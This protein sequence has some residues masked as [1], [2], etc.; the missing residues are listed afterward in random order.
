MGNIKIGL[1]I[2]CQLLAIN[3]ILGQLT[4]RGHVYEIT[5][6][7]DS[8]PLVGATLQL[9]DGSAG[10][11][12]DQE[13]AF[14]M[15]IPKSGSKLIV[16]YVGYTSDTII[17]SGA[18]PLKVYLREGYTMNAVEVSHRQKSTSISYLNPLKVEQISERE[19]LKAA[20]CNLSESFETNPSIDVSFTDAITG[21]RQIQLL[22]LAGPYTQF[23]RESIPDIRGFS[24]IYGLGLIPGTWIQSIQLS[25]GMGTV[26]NGFE[27][28]AGQINVELKK[29]ESGEKWLF[30]LYGNEL[31][32]TEGNLHW[33]HE[34]N[35]KWSTGILS[36]GKFH[37]FR[38][39]RN[40]D[41]FLD[42]PLGYT[43]TVL[44]RWKYAGADG[45]EAQFG[46]KGSWQD[47]FSGQT[48]FRPR[49][50][51]GST[52][53]WGMENRLN[54]YEGW[55]KIGKVFLSRPGTSI[56]LQV[57]GSIQQQD[58]F[59]GLQQY[60][61]DQFSAY[62][63]L[64]FESLIG[65][66]AH[67]YR[68]GAS[69]Q[70]DN[71]IEQLGDTP[72]DRIEWV[73]GVWG[74]YTYKY[75]DKVTLVLGLRADYHNQFGAFITPRMHFRYAPFEKTAFRVSAGR[76]QRTANIF[77]EN[78]GLLASARQL[79]V[80][81]ERENTPYGLDAEVAWNFGFNFTQDFRLDYRNGTFTVDLYRT[82]FQNQIVVDLDQSPQQALFYNLDGRSFAN[83]IQVQ[84]DYELIKR[85]DVRIAYRWYDLK[86]TY[87]G[88][89][90]QK[91][92][93]AA[94]RS[95]L[96]L[97]Y[98]TRTYWAFDGTL[99]WHG[100]KR[101]PRTASNPTA[102]QLEER[103]PDFITVNM[104]I[105]KTWKERLDVYVG[106]E[107]L[108]NF[109]QLNPILAADDPFGPFFDASLVWGPIFGRNVYAG[110]RLKIR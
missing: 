40:Q 68:V 38:H 54:R 16:S 88:E 56:G 36:H 23:T 30:N 81:S 42:A 29:P 74:E 107:N 99:N 98:R 31:T 91:P 57:N 4:V 18:T 25:K 12:T 22:G 71:Y 45:L 75:L 64:L 3:I 83:S 104:Q 5:N 90:L 37:Y 92:F 66:T 53:I 69:F 34:L 49:Q 51:Q 43:A 89:L 96:N 79:I 20:C 63:N 108:F 1:A 2:A 32:R 26:A 48:D 86:T 44:N 24:A 8:L 61:A 17:V 9:I 78:I 19:L 62:T 28:I 109:R 67:Q 46:V 94:H 72:W 39:D 110:V 10:V 50:D 82:Q 14:K 87:T 100:A 73:P 13:G 41:G 6:S 59:F 102:Y 52:T 103:S 47:Y 84:L 55:A 85:L 21:T 95:F 77:S 35:E 65:T 58:A 106:V 101:I 27:S 93:V 33:R 15:N 80:R 7:Q 11:S 60:Q 105:R 70:Y 97:E 76:G